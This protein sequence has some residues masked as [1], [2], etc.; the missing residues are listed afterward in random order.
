MIVGD[1][2]AIV[3]TRFSTEIAPQIGRNSHFDRDREV[4]NGSIACPRY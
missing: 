4:A 1:P 3:E 2:R